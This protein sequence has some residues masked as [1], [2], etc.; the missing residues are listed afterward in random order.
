MATLMVWPPT[1]IGVDIER[2]LFTGDRFGYNAVVANI[3]KKN[4]RLFSKY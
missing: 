4:Y 1:G 3:N 2:S